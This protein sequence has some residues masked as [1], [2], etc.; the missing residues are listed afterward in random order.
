MGC[1]CNTQHVLS[2]APGAV[3]M[4]TPYFKISKFLTMSDISKPALPFRIVKPMIKIMRGANFMDLKAVDPRE[5]EWKLRYYTRPKGKRKGPVFTA[6]WR[7]FARAK[8]LQVGDELIFSARQVRAADEELHMQ[9][10]IQVTRLGPV[11][12]FQGQPI[13]RL[14]VENFL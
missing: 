9:F 8:R 2:V 10:M 3:T 12:I 1:K 7:K 4:A 14:D 6:G 13:I 5:K 11:S